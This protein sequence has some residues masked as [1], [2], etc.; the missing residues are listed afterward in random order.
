M[1]NHYHLAVETPEGNLVEGMRWLQGTFGIR[2]NALRE[3]RGHVFQSRYKSLVIEEGRPLLGLVNYIHLNPVRAGLVTVAKLRAY[4]WSSYPKFFKSR[5][6]QPLR[7]ERFLSA[8]ELP[9]SAAGMRQYERQ[10]EFAD[11]SDPAARD[12]LARRYCRR[13]AV[14]SEEYRRDLKKIYAQLKEPGGWGGME[15]T[16]LREEKWERALATLLQRARKTDKD[17]LAAPKSAR[18]KIRIARE[19]RSTS[20]ATNAWIAQRL[21]MG[22]PTRVCN[23]IRATCKI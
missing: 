17:A 1:S 16:E 10:L 5:P 3:E 6:P 12:A 9:D 11:E 4:E 13:W 18:W 7:R 20:T 14:A 19:L 21:A 23:L 22:H 2:F 8:L 15:V